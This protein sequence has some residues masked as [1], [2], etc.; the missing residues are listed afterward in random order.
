[1][2]LTGTGV[3]RER[4]KSEKTQERFCPFPLRLRGPSVPR[5]PLLQSES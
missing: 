5:S 3:T 4:N 2:G 1:M